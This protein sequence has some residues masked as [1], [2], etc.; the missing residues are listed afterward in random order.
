MH[1]LFALL[2]LSGSAISRALH[3]LHLHDLRGST[4]PNFGFDTYTL[5]LPAATVPGLPRPR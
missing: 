4:D 2:W 1:H 3:N 5:S